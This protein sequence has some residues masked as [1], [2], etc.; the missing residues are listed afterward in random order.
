MKRRTFIQ[1]AGVLAAVPLLRHARA[2]ATAVPMDNRIES[3]LEELVDAAVSA[4]AS[5]AEA[6][7]MRHRTQTI[8]VRK[9]EVASATD[10]DDAGFSL[11]VFR[12]G[13]WGF[14]AFSPD[15]PFRASAIAQAAMA[16]AAQNAALRPLPAPAEGSAANGGQHWR[17]PGAADPFEV[18]MREKV[19]F[20]FSLS[21]PP[22][23][24][25]QIPATVANLFLVKKESVLRNSLG[26]VVSQERYIT[27]PNFAVTAFHQAKRLMDSRSSTIEAQGRGWE[28]IRALNFDSELRTAMREVLER[29]TAPPAQEG[30]MDLVI[31][32]SAL[33]HILYETLCPALDPYAYAGVDGRRPGDAPVLPGA[34]GSRR[35]GSTALQLRFDRTIEGGLATSGWDDSGRPAST[36]TLIETGVLRALPGAD[37]LLSP[38]APWAC[39]NAES[40][41]WQSPPRF[42]M[43]N[44]TLATGERSMADMIRGISHGLLVKGRG[45]CQLNAARTLFRYRPQ[46]GWRITDGAVKDMVRDFEI[47]AP[48]EAFWNA[49]AETGTS[50]EARSGGDLFPQRRD[51]LWDAPF[52]ITVPPARFSAVPVYSTR[53]GEQ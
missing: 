43:P 35:M 10:A 2:S 48:V 53:G 32:P 38:D 26:G 46:L 11:R 31:E 28:M 21:R 9:T 41:S 37:D 23:D 40:A 15:R 52:S 24:I 14:A 7:F 30:A 50:F 27:W 47:E 12:A 20:L 1:T 36:G 49:L 42:A 4:G 19:D 22:L 45:R 6:R 25:P 18:P 44:L 3:T 39:R 33:W 17:T 51:A 13:G 29:Q 34:V 16:Q 8:Q 5:H